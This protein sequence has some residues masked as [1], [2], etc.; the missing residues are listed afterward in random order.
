MT[1]ATT[2]SKPRLHVDQRRSRRF[3]CVL[4]VELVEG[5]QR[6]AYE[7]RDVSRHGLFVK[8][9][10]QLKERF[11]VQLNLRLPDGDLPATAFVVRRAQNGDESHPGVGLQFFALSSASKRRWDRYVFDLAG[12]WPEI[13]ATRPAGLSCTATFLVKLRHEARLHGLLDTNLKRGGLHLATPVTKVEGSPVAL[14]I[15]HPR[16]KAEWTVHGEVKCVHTDPPKGMDICFEP[17]DGQQAETFAQFAWDG[18]AP[19]TG[20]SEPCSEAS[21]ARGPSFDIEGHQAPLGESALVE[22]EE[23]PGVRMNFDGLGLWV[24]RLSPV[25]GGFESNIS[26]LDAFP[27]R[28]PDVFDPRAASPLVVRDATVGALPA[29]KL[30]D[31]EPPASPPRRAEAWPASSCIGLEAAGGGLQP[32]PPRSSEGSAHKDDEKAYIPEEVASEDLPPLPRSLDPSAV[33]GGPLAAERLSVV[34]SCPSCGA[35]F[36]RLDVGGL[37]GH[38]GLVAELRPYW[39]PELARFVSIPRLRA[40]EERDEVQRMLGNSLLS[41]VSLERVFDAAALAEPPSDPETG[42]EV[43]MNDLVSALW[44]V[45][46]QLEDHERATLDGRCPSCGRTDTVEVIVAPPP[47][48]A[49]LAS[50]R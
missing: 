12:A 9:D 16:T 25:Q 28:P 27:D 21:D 7:T 18:A 3:P 19:D 22:G 2:P 30:A 34:V 13:D 8:T 4:D 47:E 42:R 45:I 37:E 44:A 41:P 38:L 48:S 11:V 17:F 10:L 36:G 15:V 33:P 50:K 24:G 6:R 29:P 26:A 32:V 49:R 20:E 43:R 35:D 46:G 14:V 23:V 1:G 5:R 39:N 40:Q 31:R